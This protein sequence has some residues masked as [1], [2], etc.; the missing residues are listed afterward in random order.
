MRAEV[1][2]GL[3]E[4]IPALTLPGRC[5]VG[6]VDY[7]RTKRLLLVCDAT[8]PITTFVTAV[9]WE[10]EGDDTLIL[11]TTMIR[12]LG[13]VAVDDP[14]RALPIHLAAYEALLEAEGVGDEC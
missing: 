12:L 3:L 8:Q 10:I 14:D 7:L 4:S 11:P 6:D 9:V 13:R 2:K 1:A 5:L